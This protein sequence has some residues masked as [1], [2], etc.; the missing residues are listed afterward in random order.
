MQLSTDKFTLKQLFSISNE[1]FVVPGYQRRYAWGFK[2]QKALFE[3]IELLKEDDNHLFGMIIC[4]TGAHIGG[5]NQSEVVDGQQRLTTIILLLLALKKRFEDLQL[6]KKAE[7]IEGL[8]YCSDKQENVLHKIILG[9]LDRPDYHKIFKGENEDEIINK[10]L[11]YGYLNFVTWLNNF[12]KE[13]LV[14]FYYY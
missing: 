9:D 11:V 14:T 4:H 13:K 8:I 10:N 1:Q 3:D 12:E 5:L 7:E 2:Q 6:N